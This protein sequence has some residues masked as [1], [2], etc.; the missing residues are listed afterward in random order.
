MGWQF[1]GFFVQ[2]ERPVL[3]AALRTW[4]G[5]RGRL[6]ADPFHGIGVAVPEHALTYGD[7]EEDQEQAQELAWALEQELVAW[8]RHYPTMHFVFIRAD[9]FGGVCDYEG[10]VC[11]DRV[12]LERAKDGERSGAALCPSSCVHWVSSLMIRCISRR[13]RAS[14][15]TTQEDRVALS[16]PALR[17]SST[18]NNQVRG[19]VRLGS[20]AVSAAG[21]ARHG[22]EQP[23]RARRRTSRQLCPIDVPL[24]CAV[25]QWRQWIF[26]ASNTFLPLLSVR[27]M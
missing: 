14:S 13:S 21:S 12:I 15:S 27:V 26:P 10:Y 17:P 23:Q 25:R 11:Q 3:D 7:T 4:P 19:V 16:H 24:R 6:I 9:C 20:G 2:A 8:S 18:V 5:C 1:A 22:S